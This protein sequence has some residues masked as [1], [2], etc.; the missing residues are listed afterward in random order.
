MMR[1]CHLDTCPVGVAT[2]NP[3]LR[4][5][6]TGKPE[7]V[8]N[9]FEFIAEE[10]RELPRRA[11]ASARS[12]RRSATPSCSTPRAA[13]D[14][15]KAHGLDLVAD[16]APCR[17]L[18]YGAAAA[19][20][21]STQDHGLDA[22]LDNELI[23]A[24]PSRRARATAR[25]STLELPIR[26]V[27]RTVGTMLGSRGHPPLRRRRACPTTRSTSRSRGSAGQCFG[28]F[29]PRGHHAA[30][31]GRR[32]RLRRQGPVRRPARRPPRPRRRRSPPRS[33]VIAGNV[34]ALRRHRRRDVPPRRRR[35][36]VLRAQLRRHRGRRG[37]RRPRL[38][39]HDRRPRGRA[40]PDRP[41]LRR[42]HVAAASPTSTTPTTRSPRW[43]TTRWSTSSRSTTTTASGC[44]TSCERHREQTGSAVAER[45]ARRLGRARSTA[46]RKVMPRDYKRVLDVMQRGRGRGPRRGRDAG[47]S[48]G[49][50]TWVTRPGS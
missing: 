50:G 40:R 37:R 2:Q 20:V 28:A 23:A 12:T 42:R 21:A 34:I 31:R 22:A 5:R 46:S 30:A 11:R 7:F 38:R 19:P 24:V 16:P 25:R 45:A 14:H 43:S 49:G 26:N 47:P 27:N 35:R 29:V 13:V 33:N 44:A 48:H 1:V 6:F 41:Q 8:V 4:K 36:A 39:V 32:Q 18:P 17:E 15:W 3:E 9:F 10:V